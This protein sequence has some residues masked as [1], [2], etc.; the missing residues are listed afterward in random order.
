[1]HLY[2]LGRFNFRKNILIYLNKKVQ[3]FYLRNYAFKSCGQYIFTA[4]I[5]HIL[6]LI[7]V[8]QV[9][10]KKYEIPKDFELLMS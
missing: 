1:M 4:F 9:T 2:L 8:K 3:Y 10:Y 5:P 7:C 6:H